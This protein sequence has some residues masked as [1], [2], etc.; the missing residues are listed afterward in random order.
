VVVDE[1]AK[2]MTPILRMDS[3]GKSDDGTAVAAGATR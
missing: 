3:P 2:G 1:Q